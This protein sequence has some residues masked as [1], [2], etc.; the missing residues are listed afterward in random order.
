MIAIVI[1][2]FKFTFFEETLLS[3]ANQTDKKFKVY[4]GDDASPENPKDLLKKFKGKFD[5]KYHRFE[6]NLGGASL[7]RQWDRCIA[8]TQNEEWI[9]ILGDDDF[10]SENVV[11]EFNNNFC[12]FNQISNI[13]RF[14]S[15]VKVENDQLLSNVFLHP[16]FESISDFLYRRV[17]GETRSS[18]SEHIFAKAIYQQYGFIDYPLGWHSDDRAWLDFSGN[19]PIFS[20]N[21][22]MFTIRISNESISGNKENISVKSK[23]TELYFSDVINLVTKKFAKKTRLIIFMR[24]EVIIKQKRKLSWA[25]WLNLNKKYA[26]LGLILPLIKVFR[27][28]IVNRLLM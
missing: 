6:K 23:A 17:K 12:I 27:R 9:M 5:F 22:A 11:E 15:C 24:Y 13:V 14:A 1:P 25:E 10:L 26:S 8:M 18:M 28:M 3:L 16:Q 7:V 20:I 19:K 21:N 2:Y 4:I